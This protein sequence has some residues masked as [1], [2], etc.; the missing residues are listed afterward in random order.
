[1]TWE[2][3][4]P[5]DAQAQYYAHL[6]V[7]PKDRD[8]IYVMNVNIQVSDDGG[9]TL[10]RFPMRWAHVDHHEIWIDPANTDYYLV[11][12]DGGIYES[13][14][15]A[16]NWRH[17]SNLPVTQFY[18]VAVDQ[19]ATPFYRIYGGT[20]DNST[21]GGPARTASSH[22]ITNA[23]WHIIVGGDGFQVQVDPK[24]P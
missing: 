16:A 8:R 10:Q 17:V 19:T 2:K 18:D 1:V 5:F 21:L 6:V 14:D 13:L 15:R 9:K 3:R 22:G 12:N 23:D 4:N 7:D 20:Q 24:D 11:G